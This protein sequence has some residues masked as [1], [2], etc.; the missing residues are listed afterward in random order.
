M[1]W[2]IDRRI[3]LGMEGKRRDSEDVN[4]ICGIQVELCGKSDGLK[5]KY[6]IDVCSERGR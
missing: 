1:D 6:E 2:Y 5:K 3:D 4:S